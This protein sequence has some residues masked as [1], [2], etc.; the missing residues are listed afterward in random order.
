MAMP[1]AKEAR[2][3]ILEKLFHKKEIAEKQRKYDEYKESS[4]NWEWNFYMCMILA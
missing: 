3:S 2:M 4:K 1:S